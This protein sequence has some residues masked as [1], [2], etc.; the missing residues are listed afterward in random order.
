MSDVGLRVKLI[1]WP[2]GGDVMK[3]GMKGTIVKESTRNVVVQWDG[4]KYEM[5]CPRIVYTDVSGLRLLGEWHEVHSCTQAV[6]TADAVPAG[7]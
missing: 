6:S 7:V 4:L 3:E 2:Y 5:E 1:R